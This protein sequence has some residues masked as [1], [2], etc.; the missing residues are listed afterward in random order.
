MPSDPF[1]WSPAWRKVRKERLALNVRCQHPKCRAFATHVDHLRPRATHPHLELEL[2]NTQALCHSH[3]SA[4]TAR[5]DGGFGNARC[6]PGGDRVGRGKLA[7]GA[8]PDGMPLDPNH[9]WRRGSA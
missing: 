8:G 1:Y 6:L 5:E 7:R 2:S 3:H 9:P 4:K